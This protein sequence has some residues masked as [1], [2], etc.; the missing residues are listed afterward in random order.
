MPDNSIAT[1]QNYSS[2]LLTIDWDTC[3]KSLLIYA[4]NRFFYLSTEEIE[5]HVQTTFVKVFSLEQRWNEEKYPNLFDHLRLVLKSVVANE[6]RKKKFVQ[7]VDDLDQFSG[8]DVLYEIENRMDIE[9]LLTALTK[10]FS[11]DSVALDIIVCWKL[12]IV[13]A[14]EIAA[15]LE[16]DVEKVYKILLM[17]RTFIRKNFKLGEGGKPNG[18]QA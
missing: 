14:S 15:Y 4:A 7:K 3:R 6:M 1:E 16:I 5:D 9:T 13:K 11:N 2:K 8:D 18:A 17:L 10:E 12:G